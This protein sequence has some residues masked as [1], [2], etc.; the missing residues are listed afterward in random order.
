MQGIDFKEKKAEENIIESIF[1][2][3]LLDKSFLDQK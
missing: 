1:P 3:G 2:D